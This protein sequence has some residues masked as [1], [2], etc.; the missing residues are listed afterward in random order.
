V[1]ILPQWDDIDAWRSNLPNS[2]QKALNNPRETYAAWLEHRREIGDPE[3]KRRPVRSD[4][5][6]LPSW[7]EQMVALEEQVVMLTNLLE[8]AER[9]RAYFAEMAQ[10][11]AEKHNVDDDKMAEIRARVRAAHD[12]PDP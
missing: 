12:G 6:K 5:Q 3:A 1:R 7:L 2:R 8:Q 10:A 4:R 11:I 9:E